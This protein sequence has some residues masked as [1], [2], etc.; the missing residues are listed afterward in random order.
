MAR[1]KSVYSMGDQNHYQHPNPNRE[2]LLE[3]QTVD[4]V[5][6][7]EV[8]ETEN[9]SNS[10]NNKKKKS[11]SKIWFRNAAAILLVTTLVLLAALIFLIVQYLQL[12]DA[13]I[14]SSGLQTTV[15]SSQKDRDAEQVCQSPQCVRASAEILNSIDMSVNPCQDF[16]SYVC[17]GWIQD[18]PIPKGQSSWSVTKQR[19]EDNMKILR[20]LLELPLNSSTS[21]AE[22][23]ASLLYRSCLDSAGELERSGADPLHKIIAHV[24]GWNLTGSGDLSQF[25]LRTKMLKIQQYTTDA[26]FHWYVREGMNDTDRYEMVIHQGG[27]TLPSKE[28]YNDGQ[29]G[30][31]YRNFVSTVVS[32]LRQSENRPDLV[33]RH[34]QYNPIHDEVQDLFDFEHAIANMAERDNAMTGTFLSMDDADLRASLSPTWG[35]WADFFNDIVSQSEN[36]KQKF[37]ARFT[38]QAKA[39]VQINYLDKLGKLFSLHFDVIEFDQGNNWTGMKQQQDMSTRVRFF[40]TL[41]NYLT[42][43]AIRP[44]IPYLSKPFQ[45]AEKDFQKSMLGGRGREERWRTCVMQVNLAMGFAV[46]PSFVRNAFGQD[47]RD[48]ANEIYN[49]IKTAFKLR[50]DELDWIDSQ[51]TVDAIRNKIDQASHLF[52]YPD[53][54]FNSTELD[55][56]YQDFHVAEREY[57]NNQ[58]EFH[59]FMLRK[60]L[61]LFDTKVDKK[62]WPLTFPPS[63]VNAFYLYTRNQILFPAGVLQPPLFS[64]RQ[65]MSLN[66]GHIG[67][68][69]GHELLHGFDDIGRLYSPSGNKEEWWPSTTSKL[70]N[71]KTEC[72]VRQYTKEIFPG[73]LLDGHQTLSE[74]IADNGGLLAAVRGYSQ[75]Q[76]SHKDLGLLPG[77]GDF[78]HDKLVFVGFARAYCSTTKRKAMD[79]SL[80]LNRHS[81]AHIRIN[82]AVSNLPE[83]STAFQCTENS[84]LRPSDTCSLW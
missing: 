39:W 9:G 10:I 28:L 15:V 65:P 68:F 2:S 16:Y 66:F 64:N 62:S 12:A 44:Y 8:P 26:L 23:K 80:L 73:G 42:W 50:L 83:F 24:G 43:R 3:D 36:T 47:S 20:N 5:T 52:G 81:P 72:F 37:A 77:L 25:D 45:R 40:N 4:I 48:K 29:A 69:M 30:Q 22:Q 71:G 78:G 60:N 38:G 27:L 76:K 82:T 70:F 59:E 7:S 31:A 67:S 54:I 21:K 51:E 55:N 49:S 58:V 18:H 61:R 32:L 35:K 6:S 14:H 33:G 57:F 75:W 19:S 63:T 41:N 53:F 84:A 56:M 46:A 11:L 79:L 17:N 13:G 1:Q 74:N 34:L